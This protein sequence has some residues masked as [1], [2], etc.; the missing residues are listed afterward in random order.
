M[1]ATRYD[2]NEICATTRTR[3]SSQVHLGRAMAR[4]RL[5]PAF[6]AMRLARRLRQSLQHA[7]RHDLRH[8]LR[9]ELRHRFCSLCNVRLA[10]RTVHNGS[11]STGFDLRT[12]TT[13]NR[14][15]Q[16]QN[17]T[18][19]LP[20]ARSRG[21]VVNRSVCPRQLSAEPLSTA[22]SAPTAQPQTVPEPFSTVLNRSLGEPL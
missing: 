20:E 17:H 11:K 5:A 19:L 1:E 4:G 7:L 16:L 14:R 21:I 15:L 2:Q 8:D 12:L 10:S 3:A 13:G 9:P 22:P 6:L 18:R